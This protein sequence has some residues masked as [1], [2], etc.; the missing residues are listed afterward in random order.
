MT[1]FLTLSVLSLAIRSLDMRER[2]FERVAVVEVHLWERRVNLDEYLAELLMI[3]KL[4]DYG[5]DGA[6]LLILLLKA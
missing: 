5:Q 6:Q 2:L 3:H 4:R 1:R